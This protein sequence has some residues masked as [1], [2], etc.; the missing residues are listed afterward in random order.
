MS[1]SDTSL[2]CDDAATLGDGGIRDREF[3]ETLVENGSDAIVS[4]DEESRIVFANRSVERVFGHDPADLVGEPL[5]VLMPERF[6]DAHHEAVDRYLR[7]GERTLDWNDIRLPA[8]HAEGHEIQLSITFE[9]HEYGGR[10]VFSGIMR[11]VTERVERERELERQN[12]RLERFASIVSHDLRDPLQAAKA[13]LAVAEADLGRHELLDET[14][15]KL[16]RMSEL[17]D[18]VLTLAKQ[19]RA[20]G[21]PEP[22]DLAAVAREAWNT[23]DRDGA[24]VTIRDLPTVAGDPERLRTLFE[25]LFRNAEAHADG[26]VS[27]TVESVEDGFAVADDGPGFRDADPEKLFEHGYTTADSGT[28]FGLSIV[29]E[30]AEAHGW[31]VSATGDDGARFVFEVDR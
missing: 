30:I 3:F 2:G 15:T 1:G 26:D 25:N 9:E 27:V 18:D 17:I 24:A 23:G 19:G 14:E 29:Q 11:D 4:I 12:E 10:R 13:N 21:D 6:H 20:V 22:V 16:D 7:T 5:T 8:E 28:G 31:T